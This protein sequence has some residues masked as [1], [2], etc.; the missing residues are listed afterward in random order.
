[1]TVEITDANVKDM[2]ASGKPMVIDFW[3]RGAAPVR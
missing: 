2:I 1:M 3:A